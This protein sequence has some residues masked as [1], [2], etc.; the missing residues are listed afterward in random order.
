MPVDDD[1]ISSVKIKI[2]G[3]EFEATGSEESV[4]ARFEAFMKLA[5]TLSQQAENPKPLDAPPP[6]AAPAGA[7]VVDQHQAE[8]L[9]DRAFR[10]DGDLV[11][12][13]VLPQGDNQ[14]IDA[15]ILLLYGRAKL[16][17]A[18][19]TIVGTLLNG[20]KQS[21]LIIADLARTVSGSEAHITK[22]GVKR[23]MR[24]GLTNPGMRRA[25][26]VLKHLY[27]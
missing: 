2:R 14:E 3:A 1:K 23:G 19:T 20:L 5:T 21:G 17:G 25:E 4:N 10:R 24:Y 15:I 18:T 16:A 27:S 11:S 22:A 26:E 13:N 9:L 8:Q 12:L 7:A 6:P